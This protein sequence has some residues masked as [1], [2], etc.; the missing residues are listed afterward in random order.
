[1]NTAKLIKHNKKW[2]IK[3]ENTVEDV[4][5]IG[6][7]GDF[8]PVIGGKLDVS[9]FLMELQV[10]GVD[11]DTMTHCLLNTLKNMGLHYVGHGSDAKDGWIYASSKS[12]NEF[13]FELWGMD[14]EEGL[15]DCIK[16][17]VGNY[18]GGALTGMTSL[19]LDELA[20]HHQ[21]DPT[22]V[23]ESELT[24][25]QGLTQQC[26]DGLKHDGI[27]EIREE[28]MEMSN[29]IDELRGQD[30]VAADA[31]VIWR[32][33]CTNAPLQGAIQLGQNLKFT[34]AHLK[35]NICRIVA[36]V[37]ELNSKWDQ[38]RVEDRFF[39]EILSIPSNGTTHGYG[40]G[41]ELGRKA[42]AIMESTRQH[43]N[44]LVLQKYDRDTASEISK[45]DAQPKW[46]EWEERGKFLVSS[47]QTDEQVM[48]FIKGLHKIASIQKSNRLPIDVIDMSCRFLP[49][50]LFRGVLG[51][52]HKVKQ[53]PTRKTIERPSDVQP[54]QIKRQTDRNI[55][56]TNRNGNLILKVDRVMIWQEHI[57]RLVRFARIAP[58]GKKLAMGYGTSF[59]DAEIVGDQLKL[60]ATFNNNKIK[61]IIGVTEFIGFCDSC[62][63]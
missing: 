3:K 24:Y 39:D 42:I 61:A 21:I 63:L 51:Y 32:D 4:S 28:V 55:S 18:I 25:Y 7:K 13:P 37:A 57:G 50:S 54:R 48:D 62:G 40:I 16:S 35:S 31:W 10:D 8:T 2:V 33:L 6:N 14:P 26:I 34:P 43:F 41:M 46:S 47:L 5:R 27:N 49:F 38:P 60:I 59:L 30:I 58:Q 22:R 19:F 15:F 29:H 20:M 52:F 1:M 17:V 56:L 9:E 11:S 23:S 53:D 12:E 45:K 44:T 36:E